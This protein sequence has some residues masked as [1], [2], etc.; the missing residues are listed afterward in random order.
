MELIDKG[1]GVIINPRYRRTSVLRAL[2]ES[3]SRKDN[4]AL[5]GDL[6]LPRAGNEGNR[7]V[8]GGGSGEVEVG[9]RMDAPGNKGC[10]TGGKDDG[11]S[12]DDPAVIESRARTPGTLDAVGRVRI[13]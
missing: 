11:E 8:H 6:A 10:K 9:E 4:V 1:K 3:M 2:R 7:G 13:I 12:T 5:A